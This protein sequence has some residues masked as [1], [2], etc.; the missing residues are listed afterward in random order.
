MKEVEAM[1][2]VLDSAILEAQNEMDNVDMLDQDGELIDY[3]AGLTDHMVE[4][5]PDYTEE[6]IDD[7]VKKMAE[8]EV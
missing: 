7:D 1:T 8:E 2:A 3:V 6:D 5:E 4:S